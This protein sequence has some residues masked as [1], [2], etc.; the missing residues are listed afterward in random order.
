[1]QQARIPRQ[2]NADGPAVHEI[3]RER[4]NGLS[5]RT[6]GKRKAPRLQGRMLE[7]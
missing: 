4:R 2:R 3:D 5:L 7:T 1:M 6:V